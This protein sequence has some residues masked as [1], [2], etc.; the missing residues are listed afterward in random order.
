MWVYTNVI[1]VGVASGVKITATD[2]FL[3]PG[4][5]SETLSVTGTYGS[6]Q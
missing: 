1:K 2:G 5:D 6:Y 3:C 4:G